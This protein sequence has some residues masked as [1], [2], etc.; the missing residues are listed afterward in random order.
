VYPGSGHGVG[1]FPYVPTAVARV[2]PVSGERVL[3]GGSRPAD[4]AARADG[5]PKVLAFLAELA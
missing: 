4:E 2:H 5:W 3:L 1:G